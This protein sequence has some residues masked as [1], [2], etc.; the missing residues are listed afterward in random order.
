MIIIEFEKEKSVLDFGYSIYNF[1]KLK[2]DI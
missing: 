2:K 1:K